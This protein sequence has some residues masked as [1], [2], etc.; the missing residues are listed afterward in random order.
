[1]K[2][3]AGASA[4]AAGGPHRLVGLQSLPLHELEVLLLPEAA[5]LA[6]GVRL[7]TRGVLAEGAGQSEGHSLA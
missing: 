3:R 7:G 4:A 2:R 1:M 5:P 6:A